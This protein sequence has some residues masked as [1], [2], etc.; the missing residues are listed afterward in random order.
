MVKLYPYYSV[1]HE[2]MEVQRDDKYY[3]TDGSKIRRY[4]SENLSL[5]ITTSFI[6]KLRFTTTAEDKSIDI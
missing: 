5:R 6:S 3:L 1:R 4:P 2:S